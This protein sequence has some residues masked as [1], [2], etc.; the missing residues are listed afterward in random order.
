MFTFTGQETIL[1]SSIRKIKL[2][3]IQ[4]FPFGSIKLE[5][6]AQSAG[7]DGGKSPQGD[8]VIS[9]IENVH[10]VHELIVSLMQS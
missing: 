5:T 8:L 10:E 7:S 9:N 3:A 6:A 4:G 1:I 2:D